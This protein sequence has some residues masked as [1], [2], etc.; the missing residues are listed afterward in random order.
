MTLCLAI[1]TATDSASVAVGEPGALAAEV[2]LGKRR[3]ASALVPAIEYCLQLSERRFAD[4]ECIVLADGPGSFTGLRIGMATVQGLLTEREIPV[5]I[6]PSLMG[7]AWHAAAGDGTP[8]GALYGALRGDVF[9]A[10]YAF[11]ATAVT[12]HLAPALVP[13]NALVASSPV[14]PRIAVGDGAA[15]VSEAIRRWTGQPPFGGGQA[16]SRAGGLLELMTLDGGSRPVEPFSEFQPT[17]GRHAEAQVRWERE[18]GRTLP[19]A[20]D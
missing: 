5:R 10:V 2:T 4:L 8:V 11:S 14:V 15:G 17:Y 7:A 13:A 20:T 3:T 19:H 12:E 18:H 16:V 1:E 9:A 6:T